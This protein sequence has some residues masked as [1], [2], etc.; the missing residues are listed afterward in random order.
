MSHLTAPVE[1]P[2]VRRPA[3]SPSR[4]VLVAIA[5]AFLVLYA[6][7]M[8]TGTD[9]AYDAKLS[10][11]TDHYGEIS[12]TVTRVSAYVGMVFVALLL[13]FG[14]GVRNAIRGAGG[15]WFGDVVLL[16]FG[17]LAGT[18]A[19]WV[20]VDVALWKAVDQGD[21]S[22]I[23]ALVTLSD[24]GFL[25]LMASMIAIY[26]GSGLAGLTT[27]CLPKWLAI[28]SV[29]VGVIAPLDVL[30]FVGAMLLP[31]WAIAVALTMRAETSA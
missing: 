28:A 18:V 2:P 6:L 25:P 24:A 16:G 30:G 14:A 15:S 12:E 10:D 31:F 20:V 22:A 1:A 29:V 3:S 19:S 13:F 7:L 26:V 5:G 17:G 8:G 4:R 23:R 21:E 11:I 27:G 9:L